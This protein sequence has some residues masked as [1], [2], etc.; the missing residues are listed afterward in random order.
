MENTALT[1]LRK[2]K[3]IIEAEIER[4]QI[5]NKERNKKM[6]IFEK[7]YNTIEVNYYRTNRKNKKLVYKTMRM[8]SDGKHDH[9]LTKEVLIDYIRDFAHAEDNLQARFY[10]IKLITQAKYNYRGFEGFSNSDFYNVEKHEVYYKYG[11]T[12]ESF[13]N[14]LY[15]K[16]MLASGFT[17]DFT[18]NDILS[19]YQEKIIHYRKNPEYIK[20]L[21]ESYKKGIIRIA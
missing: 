10:D 16:F 11:M 19:D 13:I 2:A 15:N 4:L 8:F 1:N 18:I 5:E 6:T 9:K 21:Q 14:A 3:T 20:E 7:M 12:L 17:L